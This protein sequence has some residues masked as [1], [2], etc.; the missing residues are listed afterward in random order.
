LRQ[1]AARARRLRAA[2]MT[3]SEAGGRSTSKLLLAC[4]AAATGIAVGWSYGAAPNATFEIALGLCLLGAA[5]VMC[6]E[7][8]RKA[9]DRKL[10][11]VPLE[12]G[13]AFAMV[14]RHMHGSVFIVLTAAGWAAVLFATLTRRRDAAIWCGVASAAV[15]AAGLL[16]SV[17]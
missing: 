12:L 4:L 3:Q 6:I 16:A 10:W 8:L 2:M 1:S 5:T 13:L 14:L 9:P 7:L 11:L 17:A 15:A